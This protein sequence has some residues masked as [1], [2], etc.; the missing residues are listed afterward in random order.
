MG[1]YTSYDILIGNPNIN[2]TYYKENNKKTKDD[3]RRYKWHDKTR[4]ILK[5]GKVTPIGE[6]DLEG[7]FKLL[8]NNK[9]YY[10]SDLYFINN[11]DN[12]DGIFINNKVY[13][14]LINHKDYKKCMKDKNLYQLLKK[15]EKKN[16][17][18]K[19]Q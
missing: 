8:K 17:K 7:E 4:I 12:Y 1:Y 2:P 6:C 5:D 19:T 13:R 3:I 9:S 14:Y 10:Y 15:Y 18:Q 16:I 11:S